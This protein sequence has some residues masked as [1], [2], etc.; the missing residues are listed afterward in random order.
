MLLHEGTVRQVLV[1]D[2]D[3]HQGDGTARIFADESAVFTFSIHC[4]DNWPRDKPPSDLDVGLN[5]GTQ[6]LEYNEILQHSL[7]RVFSRVSP[8]IVFY[9]GGVDPHIDDR[10][11]LLEL[12]DAGLAARDAM[13]AEACASRHVPVVGVLGG[14]YVGGR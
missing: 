14:G 2:C 1:I 10:L 6:D 7:D 5:R 13:V 3:V 11:G 12:T 9:N 8:E 4:E